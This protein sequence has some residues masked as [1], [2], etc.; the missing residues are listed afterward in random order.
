MIA[1]TECRPVRS[2]PAA[3]PFLSLAALLLASAVHAAAIQPDGTHTIEIGLSRSGTAQADVLANGGIYEIK[4][5]LDAAAAAK[6]AIVPSTVRWTCTDGSFAG[7]TDGQ[8]TVTWLS[9]DRGNKTEQISVSGKLRPLGDGGGP[10]NLLDFA[11]QVEAKIYEPIILLESEPQYKAEGE[12][13]TYTVSADIWAEHGDT[14]ESIAATLTVHWLIMGAQAI[15][16][17]KAH[18]DNDQTSKTVQT[19]D[20]WVSTDLILAIPARRGEEYFVA[21]VVAVSETKTQTAVP[22]LSEFIKVVGVEIE[23]ADEPLELDIGECVTLTALAAPEGGVFDWTFSHGPEYYVREET[24]QPNTIR[25]RLTRPVEGFLADVQYLKGTAAAQS[26]RWVSGEVQTSEAGGDEGTFEPDAV[27]MDANGFECAHLF[28]P[29]PEVLCGIDGQVE[30]EIAA[31]TDSPSTLMDGIDVKIGDKTPTIATG[32]PGSGDG[33]LPYHFSF[34]I[35]ADEVGAGWHQITIEPK[36]DMDVTVTGSEYRA[37]AVVHCQIQ[38]HDSVKWCGVGQDDPISLTAGVASPEGGEL[39]WVLPEGA[40]VVEGTAEGA[41][42]TETITVRFTEGGLDRRVQLQYSFG[43]EGAADIGPFVAKRE[44]GGQWVDD[45]A[46]FNVI[47]LGPIVA[48]DSSLNGLRNGQTATLTAMPGPTDVQTSGTL[49]WAVE[50]ASGGFDPSSGNASTGTAGQTR[51]TAGFEGGTATITATYT[52]TCDGQTAISKSQKRCD[53]WGAVVSKPEYLVVDSTVDLQGRPT[54]LVVENMGDRAYPSIGTE[55]GP[56]GFGIEDSYVE[57]DQTVFLLEGATAGPVEIKITWYGPVEGSPYAGVYGEFTTELT[58]YEVHMDWDQAPPHDWVSVGDSVDLTAKAWADP[59]TPDDEE[60]DKAVSVSNAHWVATRTGSAPVTGDGA[61]FS[62]VL[63]PEWSVTGSIQVQQEGT[64]DFVDLDSVTKTLTG[65]HLYIAHPT[66]YQEVAMGATATV[67]AAFE[68]APGPIDGTFTW[69]CEGAEFKKDGAWVKGEVTIPDA[70]VEVRLTDPGFARKVYV[71]YRAQVPVQ[72][73]QGTVLAQLTARRQAADGSYLD[74]FATF[75]VS[76]FKITEVPAY[77][78]AGYSFDVNG[79]TTYVKASAYPAD[80]STPPTWTASSGS[81]VN[82]LTEPGTQEA[83][84][85]AKFTGGS[86]GTVTVSARRDL[87]GDGNEEEASGQFPVYT[88]RLDLE[89]KPT[90]DWV[91]VGDSVALTA[92]MYGDPGA[93]DLNVDAENIEWEIEHENGTIIEVENATALDIT[94]GFGLLAAGAMW[95]PTDQATGEKPADPPIET[96]TLPHGVWLNI[97]DHNVK[98]TV[99]VGQEITLETQLMDAPTGNTVKYTWTCAQAQ[100]KSGDEW[101]GAEHTTTETTVAVRFKEAGDDLVLTITAQPYDAS[102]NPLT[103]VNGNPVAIP[104]R[105]PENGDWVAD[106]AIFAAVGVTS[107]QWLDASGQPL[108]DRGL[109]AG[110]RWFPGATAP[111]GSFR[112]E[113]QVC[114]TVDPPRAGVTVAL[115]V[116]DPDDPS[117]FD[118]DDQGGDNYGHGAFNLGSQGSLTTTAETD[119]EGKAFAVFWCSLNPGDNYRIAAA[120]DGSGMLDELDDTTVLPDDDPPA[121]SGFFGAVSPLLTVWRKLHLEQDSMAAGPLRRVTARVDSVGPMSVVLD[122]ALPDAKDAFEGGTLEVSSGASEWAFTVAANSSSL[123]SKATVVVTESPAPFVSP[124]DR[125]VL[126]DDDGHGLLPYT[127]G[128]PGLWK[129]ILNSVCI[130]PVPVPSNPRPHVP[131]EENLGDADILLAGTLGVG[132]GSNEDHQSQPAYWCSRIVYCFQAGEGK[133]GDPDDVDEERGI[134]RHANG[135]PVEIKVDYGITYVGIMGGNGNLS[136]VFR[137]P[138][139]ENMIITGLAPPLQSMWSATDIQRITIHEVIHAGRGD[140]VHF[141][142]G[143]MYEIPER[144]G[145]HDFLDAD[146]A[147]KLR[148][149]CGAW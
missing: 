135:M 51:F 115:E 136:C 126:T 141:P 73:Q 118:T 13:Q 119:A 56:G 143:I 26:L 22:S 93:N 91:A 45:D 137:E 123:I 23:G 55:S 88:P 106:D 149:I 61:T 100:F 6:Y 64:E 12:S 71:T 29:E 148:A 145:R 66:G 19:T 60:D 10:G 82:V 105:R 41:E 49:S 48:V 9:P 74:D 109:P 5:Q 144:L 110:F 147:G 76:G 57:G 79:Q 108:T 20:P 138:L 117:S 113:L 36:P 102:G 85:T 8:T 1:T 89:R 87:D 43:S 58:V 96:V 38:D 72:G 3:S 84:W 146:T 70:T 33:E 81:L 30:F 124:G 80:S 112:Y 50:G 21:T 68:D 83:T 86:A 25:L 18:F 62:L 140:R 59:G 32:P 95:W 69:S 98:E 134:D 78:L 16:P 101:V 99:E 130:D 39:Q 104:A 44:S 92:R 47:K 77:G 52:A 97:K 67:S 116:F 40:E 63:D 129:A 14:Q 122:R 139:R 133:D 121:V 31:T 111:G 127:Q 142:E 2:H 15:S 7:E 42:A 53:I 17:S 37:L 114:A 125:I 94:V 46:V 4:V 35:P 90:H 24:G 120:V 103:D 54:R 107:V 27:A 131:F 75:R 128:I 28:L 34:T 11:G 65:V 132:V